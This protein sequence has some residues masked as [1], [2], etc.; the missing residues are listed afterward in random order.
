MNKIREFFAKD[1]SFEEKVLLTAAALL[2]GLA[3]GLLLSPFRSIRIG[4]NCGNSYG[5]SEEGEESE[6]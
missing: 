2:A 5:T 1:W 6:E 4:N 3:A